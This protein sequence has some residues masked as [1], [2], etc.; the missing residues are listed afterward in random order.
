[1]SVYLIRHAQSEFN[2]VF[3]NGM[4]DPMIF[5]AQLSELGREQALE[6]RAHIANLDVEKLIVSP[7]TRTLQTAE[8]MFQRKLPAQVNSLV[9]EQLSHSGDV[10]TGP[11]QLSGDWE[12]LDF[13]HLDDPWWHVGQ[14]N[15]LGFCVEPLESLEKRAAEFVEFAKHTSLHSTAIVTH[16]NF[17]RALTGIQPDNCQ[18]IKLDI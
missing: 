3:R 5:D 1:M 2:A 4:P 9:R 8:I 10:G 7:L 12:H 6:A 15:P 14:N 13:E 17:I 18:I 11:K 16:G